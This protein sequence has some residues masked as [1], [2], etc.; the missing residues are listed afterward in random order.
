MSGCL[1]RQVLEFRPQRTVGY[2]RPRTL[3]EYQLLQG[4]WPDK[5]LL[6]F[7][8][9]LPRVSRRKI[10]D[11]NPV[12]FTGFHIDLVTGSDYHLLLLQDG[13]HDRQTVIARHFP[14]GYQYRIPRIRNQVKRPASDVVAVRR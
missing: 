1:L 9:G 14:L 11:G 8:V 12:V 3:P 10:F 2:A 4:L 5:A 6:F 7:T 13:V